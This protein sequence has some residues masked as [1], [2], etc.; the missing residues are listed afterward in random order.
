MELS[1]PVGQ[2]SSALVQLGN[3]V[4]Q[5]GHLCLELPGT[6]GQ[7]L[8]SVGD[9]ICAVAQGCGVG[10]QLR[11]AT[12]DPVDGAQHRLALRGVGGLTNGRL[13]L[14]DTLVNLLRPVGQLAHRVLSRPHTL[15]GLV[16]L[17]ADFVDCRLY[18]LLMLKD[19]SQSVAR[20]V[21]EVPGVAAKVL[22]RLLNASR[23][24]R[25]ERHDVIGDAF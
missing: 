15:N 2:R 18:V 24:G 7:L 5:R 3:A 11:Q 6:R 10:G 14:G 17:I 22:L 13:N 19:E 8:A 20:N 21:M 16:R 1:R 25:D 23:D 12:L 4:D 9:L